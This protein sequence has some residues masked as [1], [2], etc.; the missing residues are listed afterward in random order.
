MMKIQKKLSA[1]LVT[2]LLCFV[3]TAGV[4]AHE[5][6]DMSRTGSVTAVMKYNGGAV[7]GGTLTLYKAGDVSEDDGNY[8]F[9]L[10]KDFAGSGLSLEDISASSLPGALADYAA[11]ARLSGNVAAIGADGKVT[12]SGLAPGLYLV[13]Q[14]Q[15]AEGYEAVAP[16]LVSIPMN[17]N[18]TYIYD[19]N[20]EPKLGA[21][22]RTP[23]A[24]TEMPASAGDKKETKETASSDPSS[25]TESSSGS[26]GTSGSSGEKKTLPQTGQLNWPVPVCAMLG[27]CLILMGMA[28]RSDR[29]RSCYEA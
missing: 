23:T 25:S 24:S 16:F 22:T 26:S 29:H 27:L 12:V 14:G 11:S 17:E 10:T 21:L 8:S 7:G 20:V 15:A 13:V 28:L 2:L 4:S 19:V 6:P 1:L 3:M 5:V 18:G 9:T